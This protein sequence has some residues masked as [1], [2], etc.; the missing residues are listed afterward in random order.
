MQKQL[1][2]SINMS[3]ETASTINSII[4][5]LEKDNTLSS[6]VPIFHHLINSKFLKFFNITQYIYII[7]IYINIYLIIT[8]NFIVNHRLTCENE[9]LSNN[10]MSLKKYTQVKIN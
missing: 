2:N 5:N 4:R 7:Y 10:S 6:I 9:R 8:H 1:N 3:D